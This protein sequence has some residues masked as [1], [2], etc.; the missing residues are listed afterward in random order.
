MKKKEGRTQRETELINK[1]KIDKE[2]N[3]QV[4]SG[5]L[6]PDLGDASAR[7]AGLIE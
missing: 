6:S 3:E 4:Q 5:R 7:R 2:L 1:R